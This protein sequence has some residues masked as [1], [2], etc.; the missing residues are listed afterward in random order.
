MVCEIGEI[1]GRLRVVGEAGKR[2]GQRY[3]ECECKCGKHCVVAVKRLRSG[4]TQ[5]CGCLRSERLS[6]LLSGN[7][8]GSTK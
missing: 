4:E 1:Y 7:P 8:R 6:T 5:S 3:V 2:A